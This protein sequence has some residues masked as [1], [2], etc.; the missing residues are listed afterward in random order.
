MS[1]DLTLPHTAHRREQ[2]P[3]QVAA[4]VRE[5]I[6][7]G[8]V[9]ADDFVR[10][11]PIAEALGVS[12]T[13]VREG[14]LTL[15][16]EGFVRLVPRRGFI[17]ASFT[18]QDVR[19]VFWAQAQ[20]AGELAARAAKQITA[21]Q[22]ERAGATIES[23]QAAVR[24]DDREAIAEF[25]HSFHREI[26]LA[27]GS[28]R[29]A[30]LLGTIARHLPNRFYASIEAQVAETD[31]EHPRVFQAL[32]ERDSRAARAVME[33]HILAGADHLIRILE[34]RGMWADDPA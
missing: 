3:E 16:S 24:A 29:L 1:T 33:E 32:R 22:L 6:F 25:G 20:L 12:N 19:D 21:E 5:L 23:M 34:R 8:T 9:R 28:Y 18:K 30:L 14:L 10:M 7:S 27:A 17:V 31:L 26:N 4:Y 2:L 13:P 15:R 11:E